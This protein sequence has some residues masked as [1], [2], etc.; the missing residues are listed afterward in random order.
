MAR[1]QR[2]GAAER[3][4][5]LID[6]LQWCANNAVYYLG[7]IGAATYDL[8][9]D[10][11][12]IAGIT[13]TRNLCTSVGNAAAGPV[14]DR[15]GPRWTAIG[16]LLFSAVTSLGIGLSPTSVPVLVLAAVSLGLA[17]GFINTCTRSFPGYLDDT[18]T[19]LQR[20]NGYLMVFG[21]IAFTAGPIVGGV[22]VGAFP[23]RS[24]YLFMS[25]ATGIAA[26]V[27][28]GC[29]ERLRPPRGEGE[30]PF[31]IVDGIV[32][33]AR[34]T[35]ANSSLRLM[36]VAGFL[37]YFAFGAFDS[38]ESLFYR[39]VLEVDIVWLGRLSAVVG[40]TGAIGSYALTR[41]PARAAG[42]PLGLIALTMLG[43]GSMVYTGTPVLAIAIAG[44]AIN[45]LAWGFLEP[46]QSIVV[47]R[48]SSISHLG[49]VMGFIRFGMMSAGV[50]P[51]LVAPFAAD[52]L[53]VQPVLFGASCFIA[54]AG[55][56]MCVHHAATGRSS[57]LR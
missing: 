16:T 4:L 42:V 23:T 18:E 30:E 51:L 28:W 45:G 39:D 56:A 35:W 49:R 12:L 32:Q 27:A 7:L 52:A 43:I 17:G 34:L 46:V 25:A 36:F 57:A 22:L 9:G 47:Q 8:G 3:R 19:G 40:L 20:I 24:V 37:G 5:I 2:L 55:A 11:F 1:R 29:R 6:S 10:A 31:G 38:L 50:V 26:V 15:V 41:M 21:N 33:G 13:L 53:G 44:Q 14:I 48:E 54:I